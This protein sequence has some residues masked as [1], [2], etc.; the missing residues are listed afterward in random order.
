L[1]KRQL[2]Y[3]L[4]DE[5]MQ[6]DWVS[7]AAMMIRREVLLDV[8]LLDDGYFLYF[9]EVDFCF[10]AT[11]AGWSVYYVP[12]SVVT[13][14][15]AQATG[16]TDDRKDKR[17]YPDYWF[18]SRRRFFVKNRGRTQAVL[19]DLAFILGYSTFRFRSVIQRKTNQEP[20]YFWRDF[21]RNSTL[22]KGFEV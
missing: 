4:G 19:A 3:G 20:P 13:H 16:F 18:A 14:L 11:R 15:Q 21:I 10:R 22:L 5:A 6:V 17:R 2:F 12:D 1:R 9:E 7:G 8:G